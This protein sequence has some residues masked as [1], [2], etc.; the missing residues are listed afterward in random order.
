[1]PAGPACGAP[2]VSVSAESP[3]KQFAAVTVA[4]P[5]LTYLGFA[6]RPCGALLLTAH[7]SL[8]QAVWNPLH[9]LKTASPLVFS[10]PCRLPTSWPATLNQRPLLVWVPTRP[11]SR[12]L[13]PPHVS[14]TGPLADPRVGDSGGP[15]ASLLVCAHPARVPGAPLASTALSQV[16]APRCDW[17]LYRVRGGFPRPRHPS[18]G[19]GQDSGDGR[20]PA[21][22]QAL[23]RGD[24][25][26]VGQWWVLQQSRECC[27][28]GRGDGRG[29]DGTVRRGPRQ[30]AAVK[31]GPQTA[32]GV[33]EEAGSGRQGPR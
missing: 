18:L 3:L 1:M 14:L 24:Q 31:A 15:Q 29:A 17:A 5:N 6:A 9:V 4:A 12:P 33:R 16:L 28:R 11:S 21:R 7:S 32:F 22:A 25:Q 10:A 30:G 26:V 20:G 13:R 2:G 27:Q 19:S 8:A 23:R